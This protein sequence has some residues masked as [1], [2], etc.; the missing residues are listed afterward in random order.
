M[1]EVQNEMKQINTRASIANEEKLVLKIPTQNHNKHCSHMHVVESMLVDFNNSIY[2]CGRLQKETKK[3]VGLKQIIWKFD[4]IILLCIYLRRH[5]HTRNDH[6][7]G[8]RCTHDCCCCCVSIS[9]SFEQC[10]LNIQ[11]Y[12]YAVLTLSHTQHKLNKEFF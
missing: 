9:V 11:Y 3:E 7:N 6:S 1:S 10:W 8:N 4:Q 2:L 5:T 12:V